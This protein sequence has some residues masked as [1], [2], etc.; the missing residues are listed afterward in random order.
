[1]RVGTPLSVLVLAS[2]L[3][4]SGLAGATPAAAATTRAHVRVDQAGYVLGR[5]MRAWVLARR[6]T[7]R[8]RFTVV[9]RRGRTVLRGRTGPSTGRW[10]AR[11]AGVLPIDL[12]GIRQAGRYRVVLAGRPTVRSPWFRVGSA[13]R[14][15]DPVLTATVAFLGAQRDGLDLIGST[16][17]AA[18]RHSSD[19]RATLY[20]WPEFAADGERIVGDLV[21]LGGETDASGGW[22]DAGDTVKLTHTAAYTDALL[23]AAARS[24]GDAGPDSL[25]LEAAHGLAW[26]ERMWHP[27]IGVL[28][29]QVGIG[30]G[31]ADGSFVGDH[32][33]WRRPETD[34]LRFAP[35]Q[36]Y[37]VHRPVFRANAAGA[38]VPPNL[39]GRVSA[40]F[41][42][43]AQVRAAHDPA[44][45]RRLLDLAAGV[46]DAA[47]VRDVTREDV[48]TSLPAAWYPESSWRD[49]LAWAAAELALAGQA[50]DDPRTAGWLESGLLLALSHLE[51]EGGGDTLD[52]SDTGAFAFA[53]LVR[54]MRVDPDFTDD[55]SE[56]LLLDGLRAALEP[57][58]SRAARDPFGAAVDLTG[59]DAVPHALGIV[60][61]AAMYRD[62]TGDDTLGDLEVSQLDWVLGANPWGV[63]FIVGVGSVSPRCVHHMTANLATDRRG[64][65]I[66]LEGAVVN[67][68]NA[69]SVFRDGLD[70]P[71]AEMRTCPAN[72]RDAY[73]AFAGHG[74]RFVDDVRAWQTVEP[75]IDMAAIA[76]LAVALAR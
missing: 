15:L 4:T 29:L 3:L 9:D 7:P 71:F 64:R 62:L 76:T 13:G 40:A 49:D 10:N 68:P 36:R 51:F 74:S 67:G 33:V 6:P 63:S 34:T 66:T 73:A 18:A 27:D 72:G 65:P 26:L 11:Y 48:V 17:T 58:V 46:F 45:A 5:P 32:D 38:P 56:P 12:S 14:V 69:V 19:A 57:A 59:F 52:V 37:L 44:E 21:P 41:A 60:A 1:M 16:A 8:L 23:W 53:D 28:D 39:A 24:L 70:E 55:A 31:A 47:K 42:L 20:A 35:A 22:A 54:A 2:V 75:A 61:V 50:L 25:V 43:A 30:T